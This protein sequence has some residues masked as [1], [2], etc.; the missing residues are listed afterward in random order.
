MTINFSKSEIESITNRIDPN[1][2]SKISKF[3]LFVGHAHSGHS[4]IGATL[5]AHPEIAIANEVNIAKLIRDHRCT[6]QQ[7]E[8]ILY[9]E[10]LKNAKQESWHNSEYQYNISKG[11]Q[12]KTQLPEVIGD[13][14]AGG[15]TRILLNDYWILE[16]LQSIYKQNFKV[17]FVRRNPIDI[18]AA[19]AYYMKQ[20]PSQFHVDR[21]NENLAIVKRIKKSM[22]KSSFIEVKQ[23]DFINNP[24]L[25]SQNL[26]NFFHLSTNNEL[27]EQWTQNVRSDLKGKSHQIDIPDSLLRQLPS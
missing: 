17:I 27:L 16:Y 24:T 22:D 11:F 12:G 3:V 4:I 26:I 13:K 5:D 15:T 8:S 23:E 18:V 1:H 21:Y 14:K 6:K 20:A 25:V 9:S 10:S 2:L 19:Y 7:I